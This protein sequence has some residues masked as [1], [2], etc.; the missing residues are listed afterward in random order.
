M[1]DSQN[2]C[3]MT[4]S[5]E[6]QCLF[7]IRLNHVIHHYMIKTR[8]YVLSKTRMKMLENIELFLSYMD[9]TNIVRVQH[10]SKF[11]RT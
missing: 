8:G 4:K 11:T 10:M 3:S 6:S 2:I 9:I 5:K 7:K 1:S